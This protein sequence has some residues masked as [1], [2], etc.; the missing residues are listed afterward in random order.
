MK[1]VP[2]VVRRMLGAE[3]SLDIGGWHRPINAA[4]HVLDLNPYETRLTGLAWDRENRQRFSE[5]T[6]QRL[7]ICGKEKWPYADKEFDFVTC[8]HVLED[9]RD[10]VWAV[11]EMSRVGRA[12]YVETPSP[13]Y[14]MLAHTG[15]FSSK[16]GLVGCAHH[17]WFVEMIQAESK[18]KFRMKPC[19]L[20]FRDR[21]V[22]VSRLH[23]I[24]YERQAVGMFWDGSIRAEEVYFEIGA[25]LDTQIPEAR[26]LV[27]FDPVGKILKKLRRNNQKNEIRQPAHGEGGVQ[28]PYF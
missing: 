18:V 16:V 28:Y 2:E 20:V 19:D 8:S 13:A 24:D 17:R 27:R 7:D 21:Y 10:P 22:R 23:V 25:W 3:R 15:V 4:T 12:G 26:S 5:K 6:W 9:I 1:S 11:E 14:E